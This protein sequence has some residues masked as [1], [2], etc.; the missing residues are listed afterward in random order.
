[1]A[2]I[3][4]VTER[5][6]YEGLDSVFLEREVQVLA[7]S[8]AITVFP[9][10]RGDE[11]RLDLPGNVACSDALIAPS[12]RRSPLSLLPEV[13]VRNHRWLGV[14]SRGRR[15]LSKVAIQRFRAA[16]ATWTQRQF[17]AWLSL[18]RRIDLVYSWWGSAPT[19]GVARAL[20]GTGI[21]LVARVHGYDVFPQQD[22]LGYVPFQE[23]LL[24]RVQSVFSASAAGAHHLRCTYPKWANR[25]HVA[26]LGV[27]GPMHL[28]PAPTGQ[29]VHLVTSSSI[30]QVK[31]LDRMVDVVK[32]LKSKGVNVS[33]S[34]LGYGPLLADFKKMSE[35][36]SDCVHFI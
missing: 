30:V 14:Q 16:R 10:D 33:W 23:A 29:V 20:E 31:R 36:I 6:P 2:H 28:A 25:V 24:Q 26:Y 4:L 32:F 5:Y 9:V 1:V 15:D 12:L 22:R 35:V 34:H 13:T 7:Q 21:P 3:A 18:E 27:D 11:R 19:F 8:H 17:A